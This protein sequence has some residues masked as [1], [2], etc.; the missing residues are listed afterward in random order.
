[1]TLQ[2]K[3]EHTMNTKQLTGFLHL[4]DTKSYTRAAKAMHASPSALSR[5][6]QRLEEDIGQ[7]L[8]IRTNKAVTLTPAGKTLLPV[9][10]EILQLWHT[11]KANINEHASLLGGKLT[12]FCSVTASYSHLPELLARFRQQYPN[13]ELQL[14]TGDPAQAEEKVQDNSADIAIAAKPKYLSSSLVFQPI[15]TVSLSVIAPAMASSG[16]D[17]Q[18]IDWQHI[19]LILPEAGTA[20]ELADQ[21]LASKGIEANV[22]AQIA[23]HEAIVSMVALG[24]GIGVAPDVVI[25]NSP[26]KD[27]VERLRQEIVQPLELGLCCKT[28]RAKE[29]L[30]NALLDTMR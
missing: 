8:F 9:A 14:L 18:A 23:G 26:V 5:I 11:I 12:L 17:L 1:M 4:C 15:D 28:S 16:I 20:R 3:Q 19:P 21:W 27:K 13:I 10:R 25:D 6:I 2:V 29:P 30:L 22:Y 7:P 24:C